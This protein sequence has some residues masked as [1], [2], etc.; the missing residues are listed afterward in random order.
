MKP[1]IECPFP[2]LFPSQLEKNENFYMQLAYNESI[3]AWENDE[4]PIGAVIV[5]PAGEIIASA[6][7]QTRKC[8]DPTAHAEMLAITMAAKKIGDWRLNECKLFVTKEPCPMCAG[9][10]IIGRIKEVYFAFEDPKMGAMGGATSLHELPK[11]N[12]KPLV[13][14]GI[15][16]DECLQL[17]QAFFQIRRQTG[18]SS[19]EE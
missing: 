9:A 19:K 18:I 12:H 6:Y 10:T 2:R 3:S 13:H 14:S 11:S 15:L 4:V 7:N 1:P 17:T 8:K 16:K 5:D